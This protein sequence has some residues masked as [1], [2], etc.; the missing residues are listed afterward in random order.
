MTT[1]TSGTNGFPVKYIVIAIAAATVAIAIIAMSQQVATDH[2]QT[3]PVPTQ[4]TETIGGSIN[5]SQALEDGKLDAGLVQTQTPTA[6]P[7]SDSLE[8]VVVDGQGSSY[9]A[10]V[11]GK[12]GM[13]FRSHYTTERYRLSDDPV[14]IGGL[15]R[16]LQDGKLDAGLV[17]TQTPTAAPTNAT[18]EAIAVN[19]EGSSYD[20]PVAGKFGMDYRSINPQMLY[21]TGRS[22][23]RAGG[24]WAA[25][26][27]GKLDDLVR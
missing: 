4:A 14:V 9:D 7:N 8:P 23:A 10:L 20:A 22:P 19:G 17:R 18:P 5:L 26:E 15:W 24:L 1:T 25:F 27:V 21:V 2:R 12:F 11:A 6:A 16:A 3:V 13:D